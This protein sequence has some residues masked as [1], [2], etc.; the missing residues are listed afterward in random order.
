MFKDVLNKRCCFEMNDNLGF[1]ANLQA[2]GNDGVFYL[3]KALKTLELIFKVCHCSR[4]ASPVN[5]F[6]FIEL[7]GSY[8][9]N[10]QRSLPPRLEL[11]SETQTSFLSFVTFL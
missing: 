3:L 6:P 8:A 7:A 11:S 4:G 2:N 1:F 9:E 10:E 5:K